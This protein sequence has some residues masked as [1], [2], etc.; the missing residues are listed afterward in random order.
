MNK[1]PIGGIIVD[2]D[3]TFVRIFDL[4][5]EPDWAGS[6]LEEFC[7]FGQSVIFIAE[8]MDSRGNA[9]LSAAVVQSDP[10]GFKNAV[11]AI[12]DLDENIRVQVVSDTCLVT[13]YGPHFKQRCGL[14]ATY[15]RSLGLKG[16]NILAIST[17]ISSISAIIEKRYL[18]P[19]L[20]ALRDVFDVP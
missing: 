9:N 3:L 11:G 7:F 8:N 20:D 1:E 6:A 10:R 12:E 19:T 17:S 16:I 4:P 14:A 2:E 18:Q 15:F 13:V 5:D